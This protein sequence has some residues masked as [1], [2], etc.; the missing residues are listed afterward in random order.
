MTVGLGACWMDPTAQD[1]ARVV[2]SSDGALMLVAMLAY[3]AA[4]VAGL[5]FV[6]AGWAAG[7]LSRVLGV[8][9]GLVLASLLAG[10][11]PLWFGRAALA[12]VQS[13]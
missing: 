11:L 12:R 9:A 6:W 2:A 4:I 10:G 13:D 1:A 8:S 5:V 7:N 3:V